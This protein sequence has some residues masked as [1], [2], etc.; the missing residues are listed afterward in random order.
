MISQT[1]AKCLQV[2][3]GDTV[4]SPFS[5]YGLESKRTLVGIYED[6]TSMETYVWYGGYVFN[7]AMSCVSLIDE[8]EYA[9]DELYVYVAFSSKRNLEEK[10]D[11]VAEYLMTSPYEYVELSLTGI[12][13]ALYTFINVFTVTLL[14]ILFMNQANTLRSELGVRRGELRSMRTIGMTFGQLRTM[15]CAEQCA[16][17]VIGVVLGAV[18]GTANGRVAFYGANSVDIDEGMS[19]RVGTDWTGLRPRNSARFSV[20]TSRMP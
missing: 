18:L 14:L 16:A 9:A 2:G 5:E 7:M 8:A 13:T 3:L 1:G 19:F 20:S 4:K 17:S 10:I 6:T 15:I 11:E 12:F